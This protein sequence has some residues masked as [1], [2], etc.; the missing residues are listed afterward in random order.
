MG[1]VGLA[2]ALAREGAKH[3][4][5]VNT[6]APIAATAALAANIKTMPGGQQ[7]NPLKP[8]YVSPLV[9][10]LS[11]PQAQF[12]ASGGLFEVAGGWHARTVLQRSEGAQAG[13]SLE[14]LLA[15]WPRVASF[16]AELPQQIP[17]TPKDLSQNTDRSWKGNQWERPTYQYE[18][19]EIILYS[20]YLG[21]IWMTCM[22]S[23]S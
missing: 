8:E 21:L 22:L 3:N 9:T 5:V 10:L 16:K 23:V 13:G 14:E 12:L 2:D 17:I 11:S 18:D 19:K 20:E 4:I 6:I 1:I 7:N 15:S